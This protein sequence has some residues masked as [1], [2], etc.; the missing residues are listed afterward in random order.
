MQMNK[1][2]LEALE[3]QLKNAGVDL[4]EAD[5][6]S[7]I[8][9]FSQAPQYIG[10]DNIVSTYRKGKREFYELDPELYKAMKGMDK[11][12]LP[13]L[14]SMT[15]GS[16]KRAMTL[17]ATGLRAGFQL[18][19]NPIRDTWSALLQSPQTAYGAPTRAL[20]TLIA[21]AKG[22]DETVLRF[23]RGGG[24]MAQ[25]LGLDRVMLNKI[26]SE[27]LAND[28]R[29]KAMHIV[30]HPIEV[31]KQVLSFSEAMN[32]IPEIAAAE[33]KYGRGTEAAAVAG[34]KN[35]AEVTVNFRRSGIYG[36]VLNQMIAFW[37]PAVQGMSK[38]ARTIAENPTTSAMRAMATITTPALA[39]WWL[40][41]DDKWYQ[42]LE[43]WEK[44]LFFHFKMGD[45]IV[46][47]PLPF[48]WGYIF[49]AIPVSIAESIRQN[50]PDELT[51]V[52]KHVGASLI[53]DIIPSLAA[54]AIEAYSNWSAFR[55]SP[56]ESMALQN[57]LPEERYTPATAPAFIEAGRKFGFSP[58]MAEHLV[59]SYTGG[60]GTDIAN[61]SKYALPSSKYGFKEKTT[62]AA[63]MPVV[64]RLFSRQNRPGRSVGQLYD[65]S[66]HM[67]QVYTTLKLMKKEGREEE[68]QTL[69]SKEGFKLSEL[70]RYRMALDR[71]K[72]LKKA[73]QFQE[74]TDIARK[75]LRKDQVTAQ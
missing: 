2:K 61:I 60:L 3:K 45:D 38:F 46:R 70:E 22:G 42:E 19:T 4:A 41:K 36:Q 35:A 17:G 11:V 54:P 29:M 8:N 18:I 20:R 57:R 50:N 58:V 37:N 74:A 64:G 47:L 72:D 44:T 75:A 59:G 68:F 30:K 62:E 51:E 23:K 24:E 13:W 55:Q 39:L 7:V 15:F 14:V 48:E 71:I 52:S 49:G 40:H 27:I 26:R 5:M 1:T 53:P 43:L 69:K 73:S 34:A 32:R 6:D 21:Q 16:A 12:T 10:K 56:I 31:M 33:K 63:D 66:R 65:K 9:F 28:A 67:E 25:P